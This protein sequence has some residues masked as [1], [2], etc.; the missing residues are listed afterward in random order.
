MHVEI[1]KVRVRGRV[2]LLK[3]SMV[4]KDSKGKGKDCSHSVH[5]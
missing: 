3:R 2:I 5:L 1:E 4:T